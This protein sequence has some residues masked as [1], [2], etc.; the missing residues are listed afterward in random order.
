MPEVIYLNGQL[1]SPSQAL[2]SVN[3]RGFLF[4]DG[5]YEVVRSYGGRLWAFERHMA[6]LARSLA[7]V[8]MGYVDVAA[9][10]QAI[11]ETYAAS[12]LPDA[13]IYLQ[14]TRGVAPRAHHYSAGMKPTVL[15]TVRDIAASVAEVDPEGM[16]AIT[17]PDLRWQRCDIKSINL[18]P[19]ILAKTK[20]HQAGVYEAILVHPDG[21]VTE[22]SSTSVFWVRGGNVCTMPLGPE[23][24]PSISRGIVTEICQDEGLPLMEERCPIEQFRKSDEIFLASTTPEVCP[25]ILLDGAPVGDGK[26]GPVTKRLRAAFRRRVEAGEDGV[27]ESS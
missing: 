17:A 24:L 7:E 6:R 19:N 5:V 16:R 2:I 13:L 25:I 20:A 14:I 3:D 22:G 9:I 27:K 23:I 18:L 26:A 1:V 12:A 11:K 8:D 15:I 4:G 21:Y 10:G